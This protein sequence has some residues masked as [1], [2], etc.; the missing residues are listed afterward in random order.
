MKK[1]FYC[2]LFFLYALVFFPTYAQHLDEV[3]IRAN[4]LKNDERY[5]EALH[6]L[7][8]H[9]KGAFGSHLLVILFMQGECYYMLDDYLRLEECSERY[10]RSYDEYLEIY[11]KDVDLY[12]AYKYKLMATSKYNK[13]EYSLYAFNDAK[14]NYLKCLKIF[15]QRCATEQENVIYQE[16]AQLCYKGKYY[17][18]AI[19][20]LQNVLKYYQKRVYSGILSDEAAV[21]RTLSQ[22]AMCEARIAAYDKDPLLFKHALECIDEVLEWQHSDHQ[23]EYL[24]SLRK[25]GKI[26]MMWG[27]A[28]DVDNCKEA[29]GYYEKY[30]GGIQSLVGKKLS[31]MTE[32]QREQYWI[33]AYLFLSDAFRLGNVAPEMLYNM[34]LFCKGYLLNFQ[35]FPNGRPEKWKD[36]ESHLKPN[37]CAIEFIQYNGKNDEKR[38]GCLVLKNKYTKPLFID[39]L[40]TDSLLNHPMRNGLLMKELLVSQYGADKNVLYTDDFVRSSIWTPELMKVIGTAE[41]I[42]FAPDGFLHQFAI[43]YIMPDTTK[44]CYRLSS[45]RMIVLKRSSQVVPKYG[46]EKFDDKMLLFGGIDYYSDVYPKTYGNDKE[47]YRLLAN[48]KLSWPNLRGSKQEV[49]FIYTLRQNSQDRLFSGSDATDENFLQ[50]VEGDFPIVHLST[51]GFYFGV[52]GTG[53]DLKPI[54]YDN[55]MS[56]NGLVF[57]GASKTLRDIFYDESKADGILSAHELSRSNMK[58]VKLMVLSACQTGLGYITADGVYGLQRGLKRAGVDGMIVSLWPV[59]DYA[60]S[61]L[62]RY[63]YSILNRQSEKNLHLAFLQA[64]KCLMKEKSSIRVFNSKT[65]AY[66]VKDLFYDAPEYM[67][68]FIMIDVF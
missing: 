54:I 34:T 23:T 38:L 43:E 52:L 53:T 29:R 10:N 1:R 44:I 20:Y 30:I 67:N 5:L 60:T 42:Y 62:M 50:C 3:C 61:L 46:L 25:K 40:S 31:D 66:I 19:S 22:I 49:D 9:E 2:C 35:H 57:T 4:S 15:Q 17:S 37:E 6:L 55:I 18:D 12:E 39:I 14:T 36:V 7:Q 24:E 59:N 28:M 8:E 21:K 32:E 64:R 63:F 13:V 26:L 65:L 45:T 11:D 56:S 33:T 48:M 41:K 58:N 68:P 27:D 47:A 51:H 16:L